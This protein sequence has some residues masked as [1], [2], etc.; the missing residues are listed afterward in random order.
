MISGLGAKCFFNLSVRASKESETG[1]SGAS[2]SSIA[3]LVKTS[4]GFVGNRTHHCFGAEANFLVEEGCLPQDIDKVLE[5]FG[6]PMG[7]F[8]VSDLAGIDVGWRIRQEVAKS[9][10]LKL[11]LETRYHNGERVSTLGDT[12]FQMGRYGIK[13]G[14]GW[15]KY[16]PSS[17]RRPVPDSDVTDMILVHCSKMGLQRRNVPPQEVI[18]RCLFAAV[19]ECFRV[20]EER[21]AE[22]PEDIDVIWQYGFS[23]PRYAGGPMFYASQVGLK[24]VFEKVCFF[25]EK[26]PYSSHWVPSDLLK[27][28]ASHSVEIPMN[29]WT[30]FVNGSKL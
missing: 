12:L 19:N 22:K 10:G 18:E 24:K 30:E 6:M 3:V 17:Q 15:Y 7:P 16:D 20:L 28:L 9:A 14:K 27:K 13:T 5:D 29:K 4:Y 11:T 21:V 2:N 8:K 25:H 23:F 1:L 26:F